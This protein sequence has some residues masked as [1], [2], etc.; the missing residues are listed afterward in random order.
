MIE[1][2]QIPTTLVVYLT[3]NKKVFQVIR[4]TEAFLEPMRKPSV[5][6]TAVISS[7]RGLAEAITNS[8]LKQGIKNYDSYEL[9]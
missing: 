1:E 6:A 7:W 4:P 3:E 5:A 8:N 9:K 2:R